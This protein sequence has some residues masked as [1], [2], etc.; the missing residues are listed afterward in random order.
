MKKIVPA[1]VM[2]ILAACGTKKNVPDVSNIPVNVAIER[3]DRAFFGIDSN[4]IVPGLIQLNRQFPYFTNDFIANILGAGPLSDTNKTAFIATRQFLT[5][6]QPVNEYLQSKFEKLSTQER[7]LKKGFQFVKYYFPKYQLPPKV[8]SYI[9]PF[10]APGVAITRFTLAIGLQLYGGKDFSFYKS[11]QGQQLYPAYISR[12]FEPEYI[13]PNCMKAISEDLFPDESGNKPLIDQMVEK[14]KYWW[15]VSQF[16]PEAED[17]LITGYTQK[18][19]AWCKSN[20]GT[21]WSF[22][23]QNDLYSIDPDVVKN[24]IGDAPNTQGMPDASPGNIGAWVGWQIV[25]KYAAEHS[26]LTPEQIMR[27]EARKIF[28]ETKYKPK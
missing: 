7:E 24:Y 14:G 17:T 5:S 12:R 10:D 25:K 18:Q 21:V 20:E 8:V 2:V 16:L 1:L 15:L 9:G 26:N 23:L 22:F 11:E 4:N 27:I 28:Q 19:T 13:T 6:Y 3:F